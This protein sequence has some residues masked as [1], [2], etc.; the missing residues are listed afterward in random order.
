MNNVNLTD[1]ETIK[2]SS[3]CC[4]YRLDNL[5][6]GSKLT[7]ESQLSVMQKLGVKTAIDMKE[8]GESDF[9]DEEK[10]NKFGIIY[11]H[12]P[13]S[14]L[15]QVSLEDLRRLT[16]L[17]KSSPGKKL[18]YCMSGNR[19]AAVIALQ[20]AL[21]FGHPKQRALNLAQKIG[22]TKEPLKE[23]LIQILKNQG[24]KNEKKCG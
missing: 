18:L 10:L 17:I 15:S 3:F 6:I 20:Q 23:K 7:E 2:E 14:D 24:E 21:V 13:I 4:L 19:V 9:P 5:F 11:H 12:F 16:I 1:I 8:K 22:L